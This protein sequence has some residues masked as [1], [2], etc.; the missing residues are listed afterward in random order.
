QKQK[1]LER[2]PSAHRWDHGMWDLSLLS[3]A[4]HELYEVFAEILVPAQ[5]EVITTTVP[6]L[7]SSAAEIGLTSTAVEESDRRLE[8]SEAPNSTLALLFPGYMEESML[9]KITLAEMC[10]YALQYVMAGEPSACSLF[11]FGAGWPPLISQGAWWRLLAPIFLH[12]SPGH[13]MTNML[14]QLR[15]GFRVER[16]LGSQNLLLLYLFSGAWGN[17]LSAALDGGKMSV[18]AST[19][20]MGILGAVVAQA[21]RDPGHAGSQATLITALFILCAINISPN[22]DMYGH[23]GGFMAGV[24]L[25]LSKERAGALLPFPVLGSFCA[26]RLMGL[27]HVAPAIHCPELHAMLQMA[28]ASASL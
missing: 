20:G 4:A 3:A 24:L 27:E 11:R 14:F 1:P 17:L 5:P 2:V 7:L 9:M 6:L 15:M 13:L 25:M 23:I 19:S 12:A 10:A 28:P 21:L 16:E 8:R 22:A 18:G 26:W